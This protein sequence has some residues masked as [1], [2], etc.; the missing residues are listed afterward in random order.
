M[1]SDAQ[2]AIADLERALDAAAHSPAR[3]PAAVVPGPQPAGED[4]GD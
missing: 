2:Y 4:S 1:D 3:S